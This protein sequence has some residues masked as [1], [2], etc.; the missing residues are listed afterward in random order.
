MAAPTFL[1]FCASL[2]SS[3]QRPKKKGMEQEKVEEKPSEFIVLETVD[4]K[5]YKLRRDTL[6]NLPGDDGSYLKAVA[7]TQMTK[8]VRNTPDG[9]QLIFLEFTNAVVY[10]IV[11]WICGGCVLLF[12]VPMSVQLRVCAE[13]LGLSVFLEQYQKVTQ[14]PTMCYTCGFKALTYV[15]TGGGLFDRGR[16]EQR[17]HKACVCV[18][19]Q[20]CARHVFTGP[21]ELMVNNAYSLCINLFGYICFY[22]DHLTIRQ[23]VA[24]RVLAEFADVS[25]EEARKALIIAKGD[26]ALAVLQLVEPQKRVNLIAENYRVIQKVAKC[27]VEVA[28]K[29]LEKAKGNIT[30][31]VFDLLFAY[32]H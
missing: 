1:G 12:D 15:S 14:L 20:G 26:V 28:M 6:A 16:G 17:V 3:P 30:E 8:D 29:A 32:K 23:T 18:D 11:E 19:E 21:G 10:H 27:T 7:T 13:F 22:G 24:V 9:S 25:D 5:T 31:A 2:G 4:G